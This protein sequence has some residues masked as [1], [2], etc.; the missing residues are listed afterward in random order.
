MKF[1]TKTHCIWQVERR[2]NI[3]HLTTATLAVQST[4][5][6]AADVVWHHR[7]MLLCFGDNVLYWHLADI[8]AAPENVRFRG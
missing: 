5:D 3:T 7:V 2:R 8:Q 4:Q 6:F 1:F